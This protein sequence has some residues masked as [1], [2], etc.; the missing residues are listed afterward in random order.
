MATTLT[1]RDILDLPEWRSIAQAMAGSVSAGTFSAAGA[2]IAEDYRCRDYASP[3][4]FYQSTSG[5]M[6]Y[7]N[8]KNDAWGVRSASMGMGG[9]F[10]AGATAVFSPMLSPSGTIAAGASTSKVVLSTALPA[11]VALNQLANRGDGLGFIVRII[12]NAS[13]SSGKIE[14]RRIVANTTGTTPTIYFDKPL[15]FTPASGDRYEFL[16]GSVLFLNTGALAANQFRRYDILT[17]SFSSLVTT[18]LIATVPTTH[19][20]LIAM[21]EQYVPCDRNP[22]EGFVIGSGTYDTAGDFTKGCLTATAT[23]AGTLTGHSS[24]GGDYAVPTDFFKNFQIR[25]VEDTGTPTAVGQRRKI[26]SHT[27]GSGTTPVYTL[28]SSWSVT[29]SSTAKYVIEQC[30]DNIIGFMGG[31][32][33]IYNYK[34]TNYCGGTADTWDAGTTWG[35]R[36]SSFGQGGITWCAFGV[37]YSLASG[38]T[39]KPCQIYSMRGSTTLYDVLDITTGSTGTW[40]NSKNFITGNSGLEVFTTATDYC[41][42]A[43]NPHTQN[44]R[45]AYYFTAGS[46]STTTQQRPCMRIDSLTGLVE[47]IAG[48]KTSSGNFGSSYLNASFTTVFQD[49]AT[50]L[51]FYNCPRPMTSSFIDFIQLMLIR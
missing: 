21:D 37:P 7:Y 26:S 14:E 36:G 33:T 48:P 30:T 12:G 2:C 41:Y 25:I 3:L 22:G 51:A 39:V 44:G 10:G 43:Y 35:A 45:Y 29:P 6:G 47:P 28:A 15:S 38:G 5:N 50:K 1:T 11:S 17:N 32:T 18:S 49:G 20:Q 46:S 8:V 40:T 16:S 19:N 9:T 31:A 4:F 24:T 34:I 27:G 23:A 42:F 13:G